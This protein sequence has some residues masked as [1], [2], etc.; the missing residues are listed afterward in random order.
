[1]IS[2]IDKVKYL[3]GFSD[4]SLIN[5]YLT[6]NYNIATINSEHISDYWMKNL[7]RPQTDVINIIKGNYINNEYIQ[8]SFEK[9]QLNEF[10]SGNYNGY[11]LTEKVE[12]KLLNFN[13]S[14]FNVSG[15]IIGGCID[16]ITQVIGTKYDNTKKF[17]RQFKEGMIWY[18]DN[19]ELS[20]LELYRRLFQMKNAGWFDNVNCILFGRSFVKEKIGEFTLEVAL[21]KAL[22]DLNVPII[23]DVDIG[24]VPPQ[25]VMIN[26]SYATF[27]YN[28]GK[29]KI[30]QK[31]E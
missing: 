28:N 29:G 13:K 21:Q 20:F 17:C 6:T 19:C 11:N 22:G 16:V 4:T 24:H 15:R 10:E 14:S 8:Q 31:F 3:Q 9:Y 26:G 2:E 12:Y 18:I 27:E 1:M 30:I 25:L 5:F 23:Y 7:E